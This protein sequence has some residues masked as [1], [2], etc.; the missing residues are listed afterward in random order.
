MK[1]LT[2]TPE[3]LKIIGDCE[4]V[5]DLMILV[6]HLV[7]QMPFTAGESFERSRLVALGRLNKA[8]SLIRTMQSDVSQ[9]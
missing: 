3:N 9:L 7:N 1:I 2:T 6:S 5:T 4:E 8:A